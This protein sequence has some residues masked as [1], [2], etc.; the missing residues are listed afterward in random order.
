MSRGKKNNKKMV[1]PLAFH[2]HVDGDIG[3]RY[4]G[5]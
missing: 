1:L 2:R 3:H 4:I 5:R